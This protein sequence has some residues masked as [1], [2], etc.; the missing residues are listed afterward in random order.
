MRRAMDDGATKA[1]LFEAIKAAA[2]P[3]GGVAYSVGVRVLHAL[4]QAGVFAPP[5][6]RPAGRGRRSTAPP[7]PHPP[8][9]PP[10]RVGGAPRRLRP[11]LP[12]RRHA[13]GGP[14]RHAKD[15]LIM[16]P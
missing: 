10:P 15:S 8:R 16:A 7:P 11:A 2:V 9:R 3:G 13:S 5:T 1:E 12:H 4:E 14:P 6:P